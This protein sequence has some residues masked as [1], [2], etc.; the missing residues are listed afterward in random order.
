VKTNIAI[1]LLICAALATPAAAQ[2]KT[3][4]VERIHIDLNDAELTGRGWVFMEDV[5]GVRSSFELVLLDGE[6]P[7]VYKCLVAASPTPAR[8]FNIVNVGPFAQQATANIAPLA[9][10][11]PTRCGNPPSPATLTV[12]CAYQGV[13]APQARD[14]VTI[15]H[16]GTYRGT[17]GVASSYKITGHRDMVGICDVT[18]NGTHIQGAAILTRLSSAHTGDTRFVDFW[19]DPFFVPNGASWLSLNDVTFPF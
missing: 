8:D 17:N 4:N 9:P 2:T 10:F 3:Y 11:L 1:I 16:A 13:P 12:N 6:G 5:G 19:R 7:I 15:N 18:I 14:H